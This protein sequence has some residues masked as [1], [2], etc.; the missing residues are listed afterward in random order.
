MY[1]SSRPS[2]HGHFTDS[3]P[4]LVGLFALSERIMK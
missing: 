3:E 4:A 1:L 2:W